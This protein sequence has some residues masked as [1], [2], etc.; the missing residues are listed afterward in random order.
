MVDLKER[1]ADEASQQAAITRDAVRQEEERIAREREAAQQQ[2]QQAQADQRQIAQERQQP[3]ADQQALDAREQ[4]AQ[5]QE[6]D[7][8]QAL[9]QLDQDQDALKDQKQEAESQEA[10]AEQKTS[11]AQQDRQ[12]IA[13]DQQAIIRQDAPPAQSA[14]VLGFSLLNP[15]QYLGRLVKLDPSTGAENRRSS[16]T[17]VNGRTVILVNSRIFAIAGESRGAGA[18]RLVEISS[19]T[20]EMVKQGD[21]DIAADSLLW[22]NGQDLYAIT[23]TG[24]NYNLTKFNLDLVKQATSAIAVHPHASVLFADGNLVTQ[25]SDGGAV[26]L[27]PADLS[28]R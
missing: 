9:E 6:Q 10:F 27:S 23:G 5:Q 26:L 2:Q 19:D 7:A 14:G 16:L 3:G 17:T 21:D 13:D 28:A 25:K 24:N 18:I 4:E 11:E 15:D 8:Q 22:I 20:L 12:Q 1:E